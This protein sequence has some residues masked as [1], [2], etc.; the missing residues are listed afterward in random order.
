V[1]RRYLPDGTSDADRPDTCSD[2]GTI[3]G[4]LQ[5]V[6]PAVL[7]GEGEEVVHSGSGGERDRGERAGAGPD[8]CKERPAGNRTRPGPGM[9]V[10]CRTDA[11]AT[12]GWTM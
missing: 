9:M 2:D 11:P 4:S 1:E 3:E 10:G 7:V 8:A 6:T 5:F 12:T